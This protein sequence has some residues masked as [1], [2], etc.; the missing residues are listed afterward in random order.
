[1]RGVDLR[2]EVE[3]DECGE[4]SRGTR[5]DFERGVW[6][7]RKRALVWNDDVMCVRFVNSL[8]RGG[9]GVAGWKE[10]FQKRIPPTIPYSST[11]AAIDGFTNPCAASNNAVSQY[12]EKTVRQC[13]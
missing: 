10:S 7:E 9:G 4:E 11:A 5:G 8:R 12:N 1:M 13:T 3:R 2:V 6:R